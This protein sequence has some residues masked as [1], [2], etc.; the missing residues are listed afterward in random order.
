MSCEATCLMLSLA[1][2]S[3][4]AQGRRLG[5]TKV[6]TRVSQQSLGNLQNCCF[7]LTAAYL[8]GAGRLPLRGRR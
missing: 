7:L 3:H 5:L 2:G 4:V 1:R 6:P 8:Q